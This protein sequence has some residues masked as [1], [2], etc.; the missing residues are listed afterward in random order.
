MD[1]QRLHADTEPLP[2]AAPKIANITA[3]LQAAAHK[4]KADG[5]EKMF[6]WS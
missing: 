3:A 5:T 6:L 2:A 4:G 1:Y